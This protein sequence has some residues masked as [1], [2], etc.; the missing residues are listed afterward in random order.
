MRVMVTGATGNV[1]TSVVR[2][3]RADATVSEVVGVARRPPDE[4]PDAG[5]DDGGD[6]R[7]IAADVAHDDLRPHLE[8]VDALVHLAWLFQPSHRPTVTWEANAVGSARVFAAAEDAG[9]GAIVHASSVG[10]YSPAPGQVVDES[11]PTHS[12]P[13]AAYGR[14]KAY[15][16]RLLD[17]VEAR[18][19]DIRV[20]RMR[21]AFI[22]QPASATQQRRLFAG[23]FLPRTLVRP[24][25][26]PLLPVPPG[27]RFQALHTDDVAEAYRLAVVG[28]VRGPFNLAA[29]PVIDADVL[30]RVLG[31]RCVEVPRAIV[32]AGLAGAW[33]GHLVPTEPALLD[34][35][36]ELPELDATRARDEL[37]WVPRRSGTEALEA[38]IQGMAAGTGGDTAPLQ[39]DSLAGR[40]REVAGGV[41]ERP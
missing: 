4:L 14:E 3:L 29:E 15:A 37:G 25:L 6:V 7:W 40:A 16:E 8:G 5:A 11:W 36:L 41:G 26:L 28:D 35:V 34:L 23:P 21:P 1:G 33:R 2:A 38:V 31:T 10:A 18:H 22:F 32:R 27:L 12:L 24:G 17:A 19:P 9:V 39:A 13:T 30:A 20:V